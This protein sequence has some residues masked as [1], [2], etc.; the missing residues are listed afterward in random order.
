MGY[1]KLITCAYINVIF[2]PWTSI[3]RI[4]PKNGEGSYV[5]P[6]DCHP[7]S[8]FVIY[9][10]SSVLHYKWITKASKP[11]K[12]PIAWVPTTYVP[13]LLLTFLS[14]VSSFRAFRVVPTPC[15]RF[16]SLCCCAHEGNCVLLP[17]PLIVAAL[18]SSPPTFAIPPPSLQLLFHVT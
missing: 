8:W 11:P 13:K 3:H 17:W 10:T 9:L 12:F 5:Y 16:P 18:L 14:L 15:S 6:R 4:H 7:K 1:M 2:I